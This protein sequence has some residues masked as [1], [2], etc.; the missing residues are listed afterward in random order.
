MVL[1]RHSRPT[2]WNAADDS[3]FTGEGFTYWLLLDP[4]GRA[5]EAWLKPKTAAQLRQLLTKAK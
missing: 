5:I 2:V 4:Q 3:L 1:W